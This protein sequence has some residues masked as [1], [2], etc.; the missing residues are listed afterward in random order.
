MRIA[1]VLACGLLV[2]AGCGGDA[3]DVGAT[4]P[5]A[6]TVSLGKEPLRLS[7]SWFGKVWFHP[8][9]SQGN[10]SGQVAVGNIDANGTYKL[11]T[12]DTPG[13]P[14]GWYKVAVVVSERTEPGQAHKRRKSLIPAKYGDPEKSGLRVEVCAG[15][16]D[17]AYDLWLSK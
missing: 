4:V 14:A 10:T 8:D 1:P 13:A 15:S 17:K 9:A 7:S 12:R 11:F 3:Y 6:G 2:M 5:V 16:Q